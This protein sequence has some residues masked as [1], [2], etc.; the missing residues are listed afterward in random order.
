MHKKYTKQ[1]FLF[2]LLLSSCFCSEDEPLRNTRRDYIGDNIR[3]DG[4][5]Y[6]YFQEKI[7]G[8]LLYRN[9]VFFEVSGD[10]KDRTKPEEVETLLTEEH[11]KLVKSKKYHCGIFIVEGN[12]ILFETWRITQGNHNAVFQSGEIL[13]DTT[14]LITK[15]NYSDAGIKDVNYPYYFYP[16]SPKPD[17]TNI[18]IE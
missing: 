13:N 16:Y 5:Y 17:S 7:T 6:H 10:G 11:I 12:R 8:V 1:L 18:F 15:H 4:F 3:I 14:F 9:G 2:F